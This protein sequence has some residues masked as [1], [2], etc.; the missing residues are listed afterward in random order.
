M[1][2]AKVV[3]GSIQRVVK[4]HFGRWRSSKVLLTTTA[5]GP[6]WVRDMVWSKKQMEAVTGKV[7]VLR[8]YA[9]SRP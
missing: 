6:P 2:E 7:L 4:I 1:K 5:M 9:T 3:V 8:H